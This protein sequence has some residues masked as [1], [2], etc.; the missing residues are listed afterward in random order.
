MQTLRMI[1]RYTNRRLYDTV[2][3]SYIT[4]DEVKDFVLK[5]IKFKVIDNNTNEDLTNYVLLQII[6]E[7]ET[8]HVPLFTTDILECMIRFYGN[9]LQKTFSQFLEKCFTLFSENNEH[10]Q[11]SLKAN[12]LDLMASLTQRNLD[13]WQSTL[14]HYFNKNGSQDEKKPDKSKSKVNKSAPDSSWSA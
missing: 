1:K 8:G 3:S 7:Q 6:S 4:L 14:T 13:I 2:T 5:Q 10:I 12:P 9:P 11:E